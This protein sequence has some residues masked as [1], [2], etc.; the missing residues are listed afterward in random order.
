M[1][2]VVRFQLRRKPHCP[3]CGQELQ[4]DAVTL[5]R[6]VAWC[7]P[8]AFFV[9][10]SLGVWPGLIADRRLINWFELSKGITFFVQRF[11][12]RQLVFNL[13]EAYDYELDQQK[14]YRE[15]TAN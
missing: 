5:K 11:P 13:A 4:P 3:R 2:F 7:T 14:R 6:D 9:D 15:P 1:H 8:C 12:T 10:W